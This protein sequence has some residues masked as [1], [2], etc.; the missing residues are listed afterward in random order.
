MRTCIER[1][2][3]VVGSGS[4]GIWELLLWFMNLPRIT[5]TADLTVS[6][7]QLDLLKKLSKNA[8]DCSLTASRI[9]LSIFCDLVVEIEFILDFRHKK[10]L[11]FGELWNGHFEARVRTVYLNVYVFTKFLAS[12]PDKCSSSTP[13]GSGVCVRSQRNSNKT[14]TH[15][16][17]GREA[18]EISRGRRPKGH[19]CVV[20]AQEARLEKQTQRKGAVFFLCEGRER[21]LSKRY[22]KISEI[23]IIFRLRGVNVGVFWNKAGNHATQSQTGW[24][25]QAKDELML[26]VTNF[27]LKNVIANEFWKWDFWW[28]IV[29]SRKS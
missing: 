18:R 2:Y 3:T 11:W 8:T 15:A 20:M 12:P 23:S 27:E 22:K 21:D 9:K 28:P 24:R 29:T 4:T 5:Y 16:I 25:R 26:V 13:R 1:L 6:Q 10:K 7:C 19:T 17:R 14:R